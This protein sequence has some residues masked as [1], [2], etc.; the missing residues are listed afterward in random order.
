MKKMYD[1][2]K[3]F[4]FCIRKNIFTCLFSVHNIISFSRHE[5]VC[6]MRL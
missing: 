4:F 5:K 1:N 3:I 6:L 2:I